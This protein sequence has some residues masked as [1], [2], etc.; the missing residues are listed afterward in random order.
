M[1]RFTAHQLAQHCHAELI[2]SAELQIR[3][4]G[5]LERAEAD[6]VSFFSN[7]KLRQLLAD[8]QAG[9]MILKPSDRK[10]WDGAALVVDDPY[11][12]FA[13]ISQL[14]DSTPA[15][16]SG[17]HATAHIDP[18][19]IL[20]NHIHIGPYAVVGAGVVLGDGVQLGAHCFIGEH[21]KIGADSRLWPQVTVYHRVEIGSRCIIHSGAVLGADG[22][23]FANEAGRWIK[24]PQVGTVLLGDDC[25]VGAQT[26]IDRGAI[27]DTV[28]GNN[29]IIDN[30]CQI[31]HNVRIGDHTAIAGSSSI[32]GSTVVGRYC[33]IGG[34]AAINGHIEICDGA[35]ISGMAMVIKPVTEKG[36]YTSGI[37]ATTNAE[38][39]KNTARLRKIEPL[40]QRVKALE[41]QV[42][43]LTDPNPVDAL[44]P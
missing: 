35:H 11:L 14:L 8:C 18:T 19:A 9:L 3:S 4:V 34:A 36:V 23:G 31:A 24:I 32:A 27:E 37:P 30:L 38:W 25:E 16:A 10:H 12:A 40:Y 17:I 2:G 42:Q 39:R 29:V 33:V 22:F 7:P 21:A 26:C 5:T 13:K 44:E 41:Q 28:I 15:T 43:D 1:K 20:G 6:Q